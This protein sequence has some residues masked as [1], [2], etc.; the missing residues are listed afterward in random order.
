MS[1]ESKLVQDKAYQIDRVAPG[2]L[3]AVHGNRQEKWLQEH[4]TKWRYMYSALNIC[5]TSHAMQYF[6]YL[7]QTNKL[8]YQ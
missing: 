2:I 7:A 3:G 5:G 1:D 6:D 8:K 4:E